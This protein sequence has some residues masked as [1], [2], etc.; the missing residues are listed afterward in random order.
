MAAGDPRM[1]TKAFD[2]GID[3]DDLSDFF[4]MIRES[5]N[6]LGDA[7]TA[8]KCMSAVGAHVAKQP[9]AVEDMDVIPQLSAQL[10]A[11]PYA[12]EVKSMALLSLL[13]ALVDHNS[14]P[15]E[16]L[17]AFCHARLRGVQW[18]SAQKEEPLVS[19]LHSALSIKSLSVQTAHDDADEGA[20]LSTAVLSELVQ[21]LQELD[22]GHFTGSD[23]TAVLRQLLE[24][25]P[26]LLPLPGVASLLAESFAALSRHMATEADPTLQQQLMQLL[27]QLPE[28]LPVNHVGM[29]A[30]HALLNTRVPM[31]Q[32]QLLLEGLT[33]LTQHAEQ[34]NCAVLSHVLCKVPM[35]THL[36]HAALESLA[37][38]SAVG[39]LHL[40]QDALGALSHVSEVPERH[41]EHRLLAGISAWCARQ[42]DA[43][44]DPP[45]SPAKASAAGVSLLLGKTLRQ[46]VLLLAGRHAAALPPPTEDAPPTFEDVW[47]SS[48]WT[49]MARD[50]DNLLRAFRGIVLSLGGQ[51]DSG[52]SP[53]SSAP[54]A[55]HGLH[56]PSLIAGL[57]VALLPMESPSDLPQ[58]LLNDVAH[59]L[60]WGGNRDKTAVPASSG[61]GSTIPGAAAAEASLE[62]PWTVFRR[63]AQAADN[64]GRMHAVGTLHAMDK[65][66]SAAAAAAMLATRALCTVTFLLSSAACVPPSAAP[67]L[68]RKLA[69]APVRPSKSD[70][71]TPDSP[72]T[73]STPSSTP[74]SQ[75]AAPAVTKAHRPGSA[76]G[77]GG[78]TT[79]AGAPAS[80]TKRPRGSGGGLSG[81]SLSKKKRRPLPTLGGGAR[82]IA[83]SQ[84]SGARGAA[85]AAAGP[86][87][88]MGRSLSAG[89]APNPRSVLSGTARSASAGSTVASSAH[90]SDRLISAGSA[91]VGF[92]C[93]PSALPEAEGDAPLSH[94]TPLACAVCLLLPQCVAVA[95]AITTMPEGCLPKSAAAV[96]SAL[97]TTCL[98]PLSSGQIAV[99]GELGSRD[100]TLISP[101]YAY[102]GVQRVSGVPS[103]SGVPPDVML[104]CRHA[105]VPQLVSSM[106][107]HCDE[108]NTTV[109]AAATRATHVMVAAAALNE[110]PAVPDTPETVKPLPPP[111]HAWTP[112]PSMKPMW[113]RADVQPLL[114]QASS[115]SA[116]HNLP[117]AIASGAVVLPNAMKARVPSSSQAAAVAVAFAA[118][119]CDL[120]PV[121]DN[122]ARAHE[123]LSR[124]QAVWECQP[125]EWQEL[126]PQAAQ[127]L[128]SASKAGYIIAMSLLLHKQLPLVQPTLLHC[129]LALPSREELQNS[130]VAPALQDADDP[131]NTPPWFLPLL[132]NMH[133]PALRAVLRTVS[134][135]IKCAWLQQAMT[136]APEVSTDALVSAM[137]YAV[138]AHTVAAALESVATSLKPRSNSSDASPVPLSAVQ[139]AAQH[140]VASMAG[141]IPSGCACRGAILPLLRRASGGDEQSIHML[142][143]LLAPAIAA[144]EVIG[145]LRVAL[146]AQGAERSG[147]HVAGS[148]ALTAAIQHGEAISAWSQSDAD[149]AAL[150]AL[151]SM[152]NGPAVSGL[153]A[154]LPRIIALL[155][156]VGR[157]QVQQTPSGHTPPPSSQDCLLRYVYGAEA[158][159]LEDASD[160]QVAFPLAMLSRRCTP[161][162]TSKQLSDA[163][164]ELAHRISSSAYLFCKTD[165]ATTS[166]LSFGPAIGSLWLCLQ[167]VA[168]DAASLQA[169]LSTE[170]PLH[171]LSLLQSTTTAHT[172]LQLF[173]LLSAALWSFACLNK[174]S[175][176]KPLATP[177]AAVL[178]CVR[179]AAPQGSV[180]LRSGPASAALPPLASELLSQV[181]SASSGH[182]K[183]VQAGTL[184][185]DAV[186][187]KGAYVAVRDAVL[188]GDDAV[189]Q[190]LQRVHDLVETATGGV[191]SHATPAPRAPVMP[192]ATEH[193]PPDQADR[194][195]QREEH[196]VV[197]AAPPTGT[198][199]SPARIWS[200]T[201]LL[202]AAK[203]WMTAC[204]AQGNVCQSGDEFQTLL[205]NAPGAGLDFAAL[206]PHLQHHLWRSAGGATGMGHAVLPA[207]RANILEEAALDCLCVV[208]LAHSVHSAP[209]GCA[210]WCRAVLISLQRLRNAS[211]PSSSPIPSA[212]KLLAGLQLGESSSP[213]AP[214]LVSWCVEQIAV[215]PVLPP[216]IALDELSQLLPLATGGPPATCCAWDTPPV[217]PTGTL[218][219]YSHA[220]S[221]ASARQLLQLLSPPSQPLLTV[222]AATPDMANPTAPS[223]LANVLHSMVPF[224]APGVCVSEGGVTWHMGLDGCA[225][226][227]MAASDP[228][229][230]P[231]DPP[232]TA[233]SNT[234]SCLPPIAAFK[235][236]SR[237]GAVCA[238]LSQCTWVCN[239]PPVQ[240]MEVP[241][242][243]LLPLL[244]ACAAF[245]T[246]L[247]HQVRCSFDSAAA[248][249]LHASHLP[250]AQR[251][252]VQYAALQAACH[253]LARA[254]HEKKNA[255]ELH[256]IAL[257]VRPVLSALPEALP[258][259]QLL[260][261][262]VN[263]D[264]PTG[265]FSP[266]AL[267]LSPLTE[268]HLVS[269]PLQQCLYLVSLHV[270]AQDPPDA[271]QV[272]AAHL[273][274]FSVDI[275]DAVTPPPQ[276]TVALPDI[277]AAAYMGCLGDT[278]CIDSV[279][280]G[281]KRPRSDD[282]TSSPSAA[283][284]SDAKRPRGGSSRQ[285]KRAANKAL[286][287]PVEW[288]GLNAVL[289]AAL[290]TAAP[291]RFSL[292]GGVLSDY[293]E[294]VAATRGAFMFEWD[295][296]PGGFTEVCTLWPA[297]RQYVFKDAAWKRAPSAVQAALRLLLRVLALSPVGVAAEAY[298]ASDAAGLVQAAREE[299]AVHLRS[300]AELEGGAAS[301]A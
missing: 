143:L 181:A 186:A 189:Q 63:G 135:S 223:R 210:T 243:P 246:L 212:L 89:T 27:P 196:P 54:L 22:Q 247:P 227:A 250:S 61:T 39:G 126:Q 66:A 215:K 4:E 142:E 281:Q 159:L 26:P 237:S 252:M 266:P 130:T 272:T 191:E 264:D 145:T 100:S 73:Q 117:S 287:V 148:T 224:A 5:D 33:G 37:Q 88:S 192:H 62:R 97:C 21:L 280:G 3:E 158:A 82:S 285:A 170:C 25:V 261:A 45:P 42:H 129:A 268:A 106:L 168:T 233:N 211:P 283:A 50:L 8:R 165:D 107:R 187:L 174:Q 24:F 251:P 44:V 56:T 128:V 30:A 70:T 273:P 67:L 271:S 200:P 244:R 114:V 180:Q 156:A 76:P 98:F 222:A 263:G 232:P 205:T 116:A 110:A 188:L 64:R 123:W 103:T 49:S 68:L 111:W 218:L 18:T 31:S 295:V 265:I 183:F 301:K 12:S 166:P 173:E 199:A 146:P 57:V 19:A 157:Y 226:G 241:L 69:V 120:A 274:V 175:A 137:R 185:L 235:A 125:A 207:A 47:R 262:V 115:V 140:A 94:L 182:G 23:K 20:R 296:T 134:P 17:A 121:P 292:F 203:T 258:S 259:V 87:G 122:T 172:T 298:A 108:T 209:H 119:M 151:L 7:Q 90:P 300:M 213:T 162:D 28:H 55:G 93:S 197:P 101:A 254:M 51:R 43:L 179:K 269:V 95:A 236:L 219:Q 220:V 277:A 221:P 77:G 10:A 9:A 32:K 201:P 242:T 276:D 113:T 176:W 71:P 60:S 248:F 167:A 238:L 13:A 152:L 284:G 38:R 194:M 59:S 109:A 105:A 48:L 149:H 92:F 11:K 80:G 29:H 198:R 34:L 169:L 270:R 132:C 136:K 299:A 58:A 164:V 102:L 141:I 275:G 72:Q 204:L 131:L 289:C 52:L 16:L 225:S 256:A 231:L 40:A 161:R 288:A 36:A 217:A 228:L 78:S 96:S 154:C 297:L 234:I 260:S 74:T 35:D 99:L 195:H 81:M 118:H 112:P 139:A 214:S 53:V 239:L 184:S 177:L 190:S 127:L 202:Q 147:A 282:G 286:S 83:G 124:V 85:A 171:S 278:A 155:D 240:L 245:I 91:C 178:L 41:P 255:H 150:V 294:Q 267:V 46:A 208:C 65:A 291:G 79:A 206:F 153:S 75:A 84:A 2:D 249:A 193:T 253:T 293:T 133:V 6:M 216:L 279:Q 15:E 229:A 14:L 104:L 290:G 160:A 257:A 230:T 138:H 163:A 144:Y 1:F 86:S